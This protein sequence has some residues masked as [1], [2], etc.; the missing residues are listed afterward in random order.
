[1]KL[2]N[3]IAIVALIGTVPTYAASGIFGTGVVFGVN[4]TKTLFTTTLSGD[5]RHTPVSVA[6][7]TI[8]SG[9]PS[10]LGTFDTDVGNTLTLMGA[11][12][13]TFKNGT[14]NISGATLLYSIDGGSFSSFGLTFNENNV[15]GNGGDQRW[16]GEGAGIDLTGLSNGVHTIAVF[17]QAPFSY[18][19]GSGTHVVNNSGVNYTASFT[20]IPEPTSAALGLLGA[21]LLLRRRRRI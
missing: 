3:L 20:V 21:G 16:W 8:V 5:S 13:L 9:L 18:D 7:P 14:D 19:G 15:S 10:D 4:G 6:A 17:Y 12:I 1:M 11:G 2:R